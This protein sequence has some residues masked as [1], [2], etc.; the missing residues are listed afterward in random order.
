MRGTSVFAGIVMM[1]AI[2]KVD[3][4]LLVLSGDHG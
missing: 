4:V 1:V 2:P 3:G